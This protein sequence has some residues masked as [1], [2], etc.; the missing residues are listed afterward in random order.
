MSLRGNHS[1][2]GYANK[3]IISFFMVHERYCHG[4]TANYFSSNNIWKDTDLT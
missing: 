4:K 1:N 3:K 2:Q